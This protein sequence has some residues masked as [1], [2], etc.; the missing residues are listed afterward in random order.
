MNTS[1]SSPP[2]SPFLAI[3]I[4]I[5]AVSTSALF[6]RYA[7]TEVNSLVISAYRLTIATLILAPIALWKYRE[8]LLRLSKKELKLG[9]LSGVFLALHF[10]TW[11]SSLEYTTVASSVVLVSTTPLWVALFSP[12]TIKEP[13]TRMV[14]IG[15][16]VAMI[17]TFI[18]GLSDVCQINMGLTCP[19]ASDF[20][21]GQA[22]FGD[23][24]ALIG[25]WMAAG[26]VL[27]G[28]K[29]RKKL[30][31]ISY[32]FLVYGI[33]SIILIILV[34]GTKQQLIGFSNQ[35]YLWLFLLA[36]LPQLIGHSIFNWALGYLSAGFVS[37]TLLGDPIASVIIAYIFLSEIPGPIKIFGAILILGGIIIA[38]KN[39]SESYAVKL[40]S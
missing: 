12:I 2:I 11:I 7:Q 27:I 10:A 31:L 38:S 29:L 18:V 13:I 14:V 35:I 6:I 34:I 33:A 32:I 40:D 17:G 16:S 30:D 28:R 5:L 4:G 8:E 39:K 3:S 20:F 9:I 1:S 23:L 22:F 15:M 36:V 37:I 21:Q 19:S 25:A 24:L 26:Y